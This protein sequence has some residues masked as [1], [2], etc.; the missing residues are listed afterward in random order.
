MPDV[1]PSCERSILLWPIDCQFGVK[2]R[3]SVSVRKRNFN[4]TFGLPTRRLSAKTSHCQGEFATHKIKTNF[5]GAAIWCLKLPEIFGGNK[6]ILSLQYCHA[7]LANHLCHAQKTKFMMVNLRNNHY[8]NR[9]A[10]SYCTLS[11][12][13]S[14]ERIEMTVILIS[15]EF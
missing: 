9:A 8:T 5:C 15:E 1:T 3:A 14:L 6:D 10:L 11:Q 7:T 2:L 4:F 12:S 13:Q